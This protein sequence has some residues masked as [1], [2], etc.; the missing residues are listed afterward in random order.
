MDKVNKK[1]LYELLGA[2]PILLMASCHHLDSEVTPAMTA[3]TGSAM[4][5]QCKTAGP[6][7]GAAFTNTPAANQDISV[8][9]TGNIASKLTGSTTHGH[10]AEP[11][12]RLGRHKRV[13]LSLGRNVEENQTAIL[14]SGI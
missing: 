7:G 9:I 5:A 10:V 14:G 2:F 12:S 11:E 3:R 4:I 6:C 1:V 8:G 13:R